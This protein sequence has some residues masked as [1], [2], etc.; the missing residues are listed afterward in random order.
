MFQIDVG[1]C[2]KCGC[3][4]VIMDAVFDRGQV[5]RYLHHVGLARPSPGEH[6]R[7]ALNLVYLEQVSKKRFRL[8]VGVSR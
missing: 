8:K 4:M 3:E 6:H 5:R 7:S 1:S 2:T